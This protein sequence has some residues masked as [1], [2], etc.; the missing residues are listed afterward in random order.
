MRVSGEVPDAEVRRYVYPASQF[1]E[2]LVMLESV[3]LVERTRPEERSEKIYDPLVTFEVVWKVR[4]LPEAVPPMMV[5]P[6]DRPARRAYWVKV[7]LEIAVRP[8]TPEPL[9][10]RKEELAV[11]MA[12]IALVPVQ[13]ATALVEPPERAACLLLNELTTPAPSIEA[14]RNSYETRV[15]AEKRGKIMEQMHKLTKKL[16]ERLVRIINERKDKEAASES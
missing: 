4:L 13:Y 2:L 1:A 10:V 8:G 11:V 7:S 14:L 12:P 6:P 3:P 9:V 5:C 15:S 16:K